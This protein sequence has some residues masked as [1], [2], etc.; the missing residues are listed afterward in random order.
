MTTIYNQIIRELMNTYRTNY[1][2]YTNKE[3]LLQIMIQAYKDY[4]PQL[5]EVLL[6]YQELAYNEGITN[7]SKQSMI[8][9]DKLIATKRIQFPGGT[10]KVFQTIK[11]HFPNPGRVGQGTLNKI[12]GLIKNLQIK[13]D[14]TIII[15]PWDKVEQQIKYKDMKLSE[16][17]QSR[18]TTNLRKVLLKGERDGLNAR[19][20]GKM[21]QEKCDQLKGYECERIA[22]TEIISCHNQAK[23]DQFMND[24][25]VDYVQWIATEDEKTRESHAE[26]N[27]MIVRVGDTFPNGCQ[28]PGDPA[29][30]V[31][32][33]VQCRCDLNSYIPEIGMTAPPGMTYFFEEDFIPITNNQ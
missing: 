31:E 18:L 6:K 33:V 29:G 12:N 8:Q 4:Q 22:R 24:D 30:D 28:F 10:H 16:S 13:K 17:T 3:K 32:E 5:E 25:L 19:N 26:Q 11:E 2:N 14:E 15:K 21:L 9:Q 27:G 20:I 7:A 23:F 1:D